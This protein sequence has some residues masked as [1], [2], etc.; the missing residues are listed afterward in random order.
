MRMSTRHD[1]KRL[2]F[3]NSKQ[4]DFGLRRHEDQRA[5]VSCTRACNSSVTSKA[6]SAPDCIKRRL[7]TW[8]ATDEHSQLVQP[9]NERHDIK[10]NFYVAAKTHSKSVTSR[11]S[12]NNC[13]LK[14]P[15]LFS[16]LSSVFL[17]SL[18]LFYLSLYGEYEYKMFIVSS[19]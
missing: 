16:R 15:M 1:S 2:V 9:E 6:T 5:F 7:A 19:S 8:L 17:V 10:R 14:V 4:C 3:I 11:S 12:T 13:Y 18:Y